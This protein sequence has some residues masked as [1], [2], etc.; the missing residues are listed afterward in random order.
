MKDCSAVSLNDTRLDPRKLPNY[1]IGMVLGPDDF[2]QVLE[3]FEWK[4]RNANLLLHG[5]GTVCGLKVSLLP[6]AGGADI[7]VAISAGF[8]VSPRGRWIRI[9]RDQCAQLNQWLQAHANDKPPGAP[10][11]Y[12]TLCY[13]QCL[14]DLVPI[15][16]QQCAPD[17]SNRAPSRI[18]ESF[19]L[20]FSW[21]APQQPV[22]ERARMFGELMRRVEVVDTDASLPPADDRQLLLE[23]VR[24]LAS[25]PVPAPSLPHAGPIQLRRSDADATIRQALIIW[26]TEVC[27]QFRPAA[28]ASPLLAP[29]GDDCLLLAAIDLSAAFNSLGQFVPGNVAIDE[30]DRPVLVPTRLLQESFSGGTPASLRLR[31]GTITVGAPQWTANTTLFAALPPDLADAAVIEL[32]ADRATL[33]NAKPNN[34]VLTLCR[35]ANG[36][37]TAAVTN[38]TNGFIGAVTVSWRAIQG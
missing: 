21:T 37:P 36:A 9:E 34:I 28:E 20:Q 29:A 18:L 1:V 10:R 4:N 32:A 23:R 16:G 11:L 26:V 14:T 15:A 3:N 12:V 38:I 25:D 2:R 8:A 7:E 33:P 6:V 19:K 24:A 27:P 22:E 30:S 31:T 17:D 35:D 13:N 5:S